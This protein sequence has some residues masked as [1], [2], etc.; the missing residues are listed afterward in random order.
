MTTTDYIPVDALK[1][2]ILNMREY[3]K[4]LRSDCKKWRNETAFSIC[5]GILKGLNEIEE[6]IDEMKVSL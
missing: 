5:Q 2:H 6:E 3:Y 1:L 4:E